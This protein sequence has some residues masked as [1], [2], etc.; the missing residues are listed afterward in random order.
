[1]SSRTLA[2]VL[3][4]ALFLVPSLAADAS[5]RWLRGA[6]V[7]EFTDA[8]WDILKGEAQRVLNEVETAVRVDWRNED[9]GNSG[10]MKVIL[11]FDY[12]GSHCRRLAFLNLSAKGVRGVAN[13][14]LCLQADG[15]WKYLSDS[16]VR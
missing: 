8:D 10:A 3:L 6:A 5:W 1:M 15:T 11:D 7:A 16:E 12:D 2:V 9:T 13:Y 4:S 14:N